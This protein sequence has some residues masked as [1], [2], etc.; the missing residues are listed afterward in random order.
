LVETVSGL[1]LLIQ[2][3]LIFGGIGVACLGLVYLKQ[4]S[5]LTRAQ[6]KPCP[7]RPPLAI[8]QY[9]LT[10]CLQRTLLRISTISS[11]SSS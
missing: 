8:T 2:A 10:T 7:C 1:S 6:G 3:R 9:G 11:Q 4:R 5:S